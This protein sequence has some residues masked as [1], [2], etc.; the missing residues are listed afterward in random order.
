M[1][2]YFIL[3]PIVF[4]LDR[5]SKFLALALSNNEYIVNNFLSF[6]L[7][8]NRGI[9]WSIGHSSNKYIFFF[10]TFIIIL[11]TFFLFLFAYSRDK[12]GKNIYG[13]TL[14]LAGS[15]SNIVD[16][17]LYDG[18]VDFISFHY[19]GWYFPNFNIADV[20]IFLGV[21]L[22]FREIKREL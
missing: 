15:I 11:V 4:L 19:K 7:S 9:S 18:V 10:I 16:R 21:M 3:F 17:F 1:S 8:F 6:Q 14:V 5:L 20:A 2:Y 12:I 13:E 22:M